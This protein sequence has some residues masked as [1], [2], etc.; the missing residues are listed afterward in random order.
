MNL[1]KNFALFLFVF[2]LTDGHAQQ[3]NDSLNATP[4][5]DNFICWTYHRPNTNI[6]G[7]SL[8]LFSSSTQNVNSNGLRIE[9]LG[10]G[11]LLGFLPKSPVVE[12]DSAFNR[13]EKS[14]E[15]INGVNISAFGS[16]SNNSVNGLTLGLMG[17][18]HKQ[19]NGL[20]MTIFANMVQEQNGLMIAFS[21]EAFS[22]K[23]AQIGLFNKAKQQK[24]V[25]IGLVNKAQQQKGLQI[26][27]WNV[28][29]KRKLP[30][31]NWDFSKN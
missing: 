29:G 6:N 24:G 1:F 8:G 11:L 22:M 19:V 21:N 12:T 26:G 5:R 20:S 16:L 17:Q 27:L 15:K 18:L 3:A 13:L 2:Y 7:L 9:L 4:N 30:I 31:I 23:G 10:E 28:N 14:G 25:Q